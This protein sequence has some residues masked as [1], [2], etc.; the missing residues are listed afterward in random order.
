MDHW[1]S[2]ISKG[3]AL[4]ASAVRDLHE[5]GFVVIPGP[6]ESDR[7]ARLGEAYDSAVAGATSDDVSTGSSTTRINDFVNRGPE[8][9][10]VCEFQVG[11]LRKQK[12][13]GCGKARCLLCHYDKI[14]GIASV[15]DR[16][17]RRRGSS[18]RCVIILT[19]NDWF[20]S[21]ARFAGLGSFKGT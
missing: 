21:A 10:C 16:V 9:D 5:V 12:A 18:I 14:L 6:L 1:F 2:G 8:F 20:R 3:S 11:R 13:L 19:V 15:R 4:P 7:L 17:R